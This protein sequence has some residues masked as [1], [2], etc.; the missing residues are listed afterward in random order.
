VIVEGSASDDGRNVIAVSASATGVVVYRTEPL[1]AGGRRLAW[2]DRSGAEMLSVE[3]GERG[4]AFALSP[5]EGRMAIARVAG[6]NSD[7][8]MIDLRRGVPSRF[9]TAASLE[10]HPLFSADGSQLFYQRFFTDRGVIGI[11]AR[12]VSGGEEESLIEGTPGV[13]ATDVSRDGQFLLLK[14]AEGVE[15]AVGFSDWDILALPLSGDRTPIPAVVTPFD[16]RDGQ[17]SPDAA[18]L[19]YQSDESGQ[20]EVYLQPFGR[21]GERVQV[22]VGGGAQ[23][24]WRADGREIFYVALDGRLMAVSVQPSA[25]ATASPTLGRPEPLFVASMGPVVPAIARQWYV[26]SPDGQRFLMG[27]VDATTASPLEVI[28]NFNPSQRSP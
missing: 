17:F 11:V 1:G 7:I 15:G 12:P 22:S 24:R 8:W 6:G 5:D 16:E 20:F 3:G 18:W 26:P 23:A 21:E 14:S 28:L 2:F 4:G 25:D 10:S 27:V 9:T 13:I 19:L